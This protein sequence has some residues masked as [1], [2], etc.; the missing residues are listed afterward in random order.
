[1]RRVLSA[2]APAGK[3]EEKLDLEAPRTTTL[4]QRRPSA[5]LAA[6]TTRWP[7][8]FVMPGELRKALV[9]QLGSMSA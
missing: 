3:D 8:P 4:A 6:S 5:D 9:K 2:V 1:M 7:V